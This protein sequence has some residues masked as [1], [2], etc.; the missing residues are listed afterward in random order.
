LW[1]KEFIV[2]PYSAGNGENTVKFIQEIK[3]YHPEQT[4]L[5]IWDGASYH[6]G[7]EVKNLL[8]IENEGK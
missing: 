8:A 5:L 7:E 4:L 6:R 3:I 2:A 1:T